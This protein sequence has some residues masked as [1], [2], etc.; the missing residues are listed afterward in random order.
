MLSEEDSKSSTFPNLFGVYKFPNF[1]VSVK[2]SLNSC[3]LT[4][5]SEPTFC[6]LRP[7][8]SCGIGLSSAG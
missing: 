5:P 4:F 6:A 1:N 2:H 8:S 7:T 3:S